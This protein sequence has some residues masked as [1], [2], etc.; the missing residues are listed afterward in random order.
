MKKRNLYGILAIGVFFVLFLASCKLTI[1]TFVAPDTIDSGTVF[2]I[3]ID[4]NGYSPLG[5]SATKHGLAIQIPTNW[6]IIQAYAV[7]SNNVT[8]ILTYD[9]SFSDAYTSEEG[10]YV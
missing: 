8:Y 2:N 5:D 9:E 6:K 7:G 4:G 3:T 1:I 10:Y